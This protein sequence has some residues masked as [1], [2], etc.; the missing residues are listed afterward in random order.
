MKPIIPEEKH[1]TCTDLSD[2]DE[3]CHSSWINGYNAF[4]NELLTNLK[5]RGV[6]EVKEVILKWIDANPM[7]D[8]LKELPT[9]MSKKLPRGL[10]SAIVEALKGDV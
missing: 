10:A 2:I 6:D 9:F 8:I 1:F 5:E 7:E 3:L 4:R